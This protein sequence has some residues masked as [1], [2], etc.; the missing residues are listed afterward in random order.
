MR[1]YVCVGCSRC[2]DNADCPRFW[3]DFPIDLQAQLGE[4]LQ[5]AFPKAHFSLTEAKNGMDFFLLWHHSANDSLTLS[6]SFSS[7][8]T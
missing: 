6:L 5:S 1:M 7:F 4:F 3:D 2:R 8:E